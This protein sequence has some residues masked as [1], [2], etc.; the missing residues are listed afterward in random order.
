MYELVEMIF[1]SLCWGTPDENVD[2]YCNKKRNYISEIC[3]AVLTICLQFAVACS[4]GVE[5]GVEAKKPGF[6]KKTPDWRRDRRNN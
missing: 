3:A 5:C 2:L 6:K 4:V 1:V